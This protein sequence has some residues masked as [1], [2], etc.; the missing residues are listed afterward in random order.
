M[1]TGLENKKLLITGA[2]RGIGKRIKEVFM[3]CGAQVIAPGREELDLS[4]KESICEWLKQNQSLEPDIFIHCA[5]VNELASL[6]EIRMEVLERVF[7]VNYYAPVMLLKQF[8][9]H[10]KN[11]GWGRI[12][13]VS[14]IYALVSKEHR[15]AYASSKHA[16]TGLVKTLTLELAGDGILTNAVAPGYVWT[17]LTRKNLSTDEIKKIQDMIPTGKLQTAEDIAML[18]AFL[19]S[20][21]N[22][23]IT[24]QLI[25]V[26][27]GYTC[28]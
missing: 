26:D 17:D 4:A 5:A 15:A 20:D 27:G 14:S 11:H 2:S 13:L 12:V 3:E 10:M 1:N 16:L 28:R 7:W 24:G 8:C 18:S 23:S 9:K 25:A 6:D 22:K 19:C 21:Y